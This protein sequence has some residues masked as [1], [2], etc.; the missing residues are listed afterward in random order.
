MAENIL[1]IKELREEAGLSQPQLADA[2]GVAQS[3]VSS[4]EAGTYLPRV[5]QLPLLAGVL[6]CDYNALFAEAPYRYSTA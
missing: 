2:M 4:W 6:G 5:R 1:R 3:A